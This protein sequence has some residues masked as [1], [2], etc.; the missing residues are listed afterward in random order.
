MSSNFERL[1][2]IINQAYAE[3]FSILTQKMANPLIFP[4][5]HFLIGIPFCKFSA[6]R[7]KFHKFFLIT[8]PIFET[9]YKNLLGQYDWKNFCRLKVLDECFK[10]GQAAVTWIANPVKFA[11]LIRYDA[12]FY[13]FSIE[14]HGTG[15]YLPEK[16]KKERKWHTFINFLHSLGLFF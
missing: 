10:L 8:K 11:T 9:K 6:F 16:K 1:H 3:N 2:E 5:L 7:L 15:S 14:I 13:L 12:L 4:P